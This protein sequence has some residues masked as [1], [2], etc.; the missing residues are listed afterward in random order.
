MTD[1]M[2]ATSLSLQKFLPMS[3][4]EGQ[5]ICKYLHR[6]PLS[7]A[8]PSSRGPFIYTSNAGSSAIIIIREEIVSNQM[9]IVT[10]SRKLSQIT[11]ACF[12]LLSLVQCSNHSFI[13]FQSTLTAA[14]GQH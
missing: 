1:A 12:G 7:A 3:K 13:F 14:V 6:L 2:L 4:N 5:N 10:F 8:T 11:S 9:S